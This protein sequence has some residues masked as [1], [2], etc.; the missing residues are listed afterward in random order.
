MKVYDLFNAVARNRGPRD[1]RLA[2]DGDWGLALI[3]L[4]SANAVTV[5]CCCS[6]SRLPGL[7]YADS[8]GWV[9]KA[10]LAPV[11]GTKIARSAATPVRS[12]HVRTPGPLIFARSS[13]APDPAQRKPSTSDVARR[14]RNA[15]KRERA[16][17]CAGRPYGCRMADIPEVP[18]GG[19]GFC[20]RT[21]AR[22]SVESAFSELLTTPQ[23]R[24]AVP[25]SRD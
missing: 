3:G 19:R 20:Y 25:M 12:G 10:P 6:C 11:V 18:V 9:A 1:A 14:K 17:A 24:P 21:A 4:F 5:S 15:T 22:G 2:P 13:S 16:P 8:R 7:R 23:H